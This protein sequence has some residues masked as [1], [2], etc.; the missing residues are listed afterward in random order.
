MNKLD[1]RI[2]KTR[3]NIELAI[4][5]LL[6]EK[7]L[8]DIS[9]TELC[10]ESGITRRTFYLHYDSVQQ[11]FE[12]LMKKLLSELDESI[13]KVKHNRMNTKSLHITALLQ[14]VSD[15]QYF[16]EIAFA[17]HTHFAIYELILSHLKIIVKNSMIEMV[18]TNTTLIDYEVSYRA[19]AILGLIHEWLNNKCSLPIEEIDTIATRLI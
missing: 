18:E 10:K 15:N 16:Y 12:G 2:I 11:L 14:H 3:K 7:S 17:K 1:E 5:S 6:K 13:L 19:S 8:G 4:F 9:V